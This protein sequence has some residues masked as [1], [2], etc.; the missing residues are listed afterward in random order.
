MPAAISANA[1]LFL[2]V[3]FCFSKHTSTGA[4]RLGFDIRTHRHAARLANVPVSSSKHSGALTLVVEGY[5]ESSD[6]PRK[7]GQT[8]RRQHEAC[9][10]DNRQA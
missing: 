4:G 10:E 9:H 6:P 5:I 3:P 2:I 1:V 7:L 8:H